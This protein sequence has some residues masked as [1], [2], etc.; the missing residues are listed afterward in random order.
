MQNTI[1]I[2][3][4]FNPSIYNNNFANLFYKY[5]ANI[6]VFPTEKNSPYDSLNIVNFLQKNCLSREENH[7]IFIGFSAGVVGALGAGRLWQRQGGQVLALLA[8][9]GWGVPLIADFPIHCLSHDSFTH[10]C[11]TFWVKN[12]KHF[13]AYPRV[14]HQDIWRSPL[15]IQGYYY[16]DNKT[17]K[18]INQM[19]FLKLILYKYLSF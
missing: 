19:D 4:G 8:F 17:V 9:D 12:S 13:V 6:L 11:S 3:G 14:S 10:Y 15:T 5:R 1:I 16:D 18:K 7:L 2:C